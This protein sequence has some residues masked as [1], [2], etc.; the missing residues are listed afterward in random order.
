MHN[1]TNPVET[2]PRQSCNRRGLLAAGLGLGGIA[3][4]A[5]LHPALASDMAAQGRT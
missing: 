1:N 4:L 3:G 5:S 2:S